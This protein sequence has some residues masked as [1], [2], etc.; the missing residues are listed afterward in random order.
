VKA[1]VCLP[2]TT[3]PFDLPAGEPS[4]DICHYI[5]KEKDTK[6]I[7]DLGKRRCKLQVASGKLQV[8][9]CKWQ[10]ASGKM[11]VARCKW[12]DASNKRQGLRIVDFGIWI[13]DC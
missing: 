12:Q 2:L 5:R 13:L 1:Y 7:E 4:S 9:R 10:D 8:A 11:Q 3:I 6:N